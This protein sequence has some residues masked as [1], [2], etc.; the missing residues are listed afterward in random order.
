LIVEAGIAV[1]VAR[2]KEQWAV[3]A[4]ATAYEETIKREEIHSGLILYATEDGWN[5]GPL[6]YALELS[7]GNDVDSDDERWAVFLWR[8]GGPTCPK[9]LWRSAADY[10]NGAAGAPVGWS[11]SLRA[12]AFVRQIV[13]GEGRISFLDG[14][15]AAGLLLYALGREDQ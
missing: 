5:N 3:E 7:G 15:Q 4:Y 9:F 8:D 2:Q 14:H 11:P 12:L 10:V 6:P 1:N 13:D